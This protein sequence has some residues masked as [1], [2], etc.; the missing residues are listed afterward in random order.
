MWTGVPEAIL[1]LRS[2]PEEVPP[3]RRVRGQWIAA[4]LR[5]VRDRGLWTQYFA[6]LPREYHATIQ[7]MIPSQWLLAHVVVAH[8][9][10]LDA[11]QLPEA[12][13]E[14]MGASVVIRGQGKAIEV[15]L[16]LLPL[17]LLD[18][19]SF[20]ARTDALWDRAFDGGAPAVYKLGPKE[21]RFDVHGLPFAHL[22]YPRIAIRGVITGAVR[23]LVRTVYVQDI[24]RN[25]QP[26]VLSYRVQ[27]V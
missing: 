5:A 16:K 15:V 10:A 3:V 25:R 17:H 7:S 19:F 14:A 9:A 8:Y 20:I 18:V 12:D 2:A 1:K 23:L 11:L 22:R 24:T 21:A 4:S 13:I 27:W 26:P 6:N